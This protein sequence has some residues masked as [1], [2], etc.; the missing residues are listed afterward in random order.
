MN[1]D[2]IIIGSGPAGLTAAIYAARYKL[3]MLVIGKLPGGTGTK[4][5]EVCNFPTY[6]KING[7]ELMMKMINHAKELGIEILTEEVT[8]LIKR[9]ELFEVITKK[10]RYTASKIIIA[11][12]SE[13]KNLNLEK[14][15]E[16]VGKGISYCATC[17]APFYKDKVVA[18]IGGGNAA[19]TSALLLTKFAKK[20]YIIYRR[21]NFCRAEKSWIDDVKKNEK[22]EAIFNSNIA[23]LIGENRLEAI[24]LDN[25]NVIK[26]D[27]LF[28]EVG[29]VP[30]TNIVEKLGVKF[31]CEEIMVNKEQKTNIKGL[32]A[33]GDVTNNSLKQIVTACSEGA[34]ASSSA[35]R[36]IEDEKINN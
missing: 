16:L 33:A 8:D 24:E 2:L 7:S 29:S 17:D 22:I 30:N 36:E 27:G 19:L 20:V 15:K 5:Y 10:N 18:V 23:K 31:D 4:A 21:A 14:E 9:D 26:I 13:R 6:A 28:V 35:Y 25:K 1:Y 12:G 3:N 11:T 32:F 34:V